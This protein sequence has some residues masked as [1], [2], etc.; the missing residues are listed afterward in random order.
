MSKP[1]LTAAHASARRVCRP[2]P[3]S[4]F[5]DDTRNRADHHVFYVLGFGITGAI[6]TNALV[7][8]YFAMVYVSG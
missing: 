7:F 8:F 2:V 4:T 3:I 6:V 5:R 1:N